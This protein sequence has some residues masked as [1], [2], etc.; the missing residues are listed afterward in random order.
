MLQQMLA[1]PER[2]SASTSVAAAAV[3]V[4][5]MDDHEA[6]LRR[7]HRRRADTQVPAMVQTF[8]GCPGI[9]VVHPDHAGK[10]VIGNVLDR[11][12]KGAWLFA[13]D[14][15]ANPDQVRKLHVDH[16]SWTAALGYW[17]LNPP[18]SRGRWCRCWCGCSAMV[19]SDVAKNLRALDRIADHPPTSA[20]VPV[21]RSAHASPTLNSRRASGPPAE[22]RHP[23]PVASADPPAGGPAATDP[24]QG[25]ERGQRLRLVQ[26][27]DVARRGIRTGGRQDAVDG[28]PG[29]LVGALHGGQIGVGPDRSRR[30]GNRLGIRVTAS[31]RSAHE[32][33]VLISSGFEGWWPRS[34]SAAGSP[35]PGTSCAHHHHVPRPGRSRRRRRPV[36]ATPR[37]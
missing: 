31:G 13:V 34:G 23:D 25:A 37:P 24:V 9:P 14:L 22:V 35:G 17:Y 10:Y 30:P 21:A 36:A 32:P 28:P 33:A 1:R 4:V 26:R 11:F 18:R 16:T 8:N 15:A 5:P 2:A 20:G 29:R 27:P 12:R 6:R 3:P 7:H 19:S